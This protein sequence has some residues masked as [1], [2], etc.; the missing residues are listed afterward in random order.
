MRRM[1]HSATLTA[2]S[3][4]SPQPFKLLQHD[5][6]PWLGTA[7]GHQVMLQVPCPEV[8]CN[9]IHCIGAKPRKMIVKEEIKVQVQ[10]PNQTM[11]TLVGMRCG[12]AG[13]GYWSPMT[14]RPARLPGMLTSR[15]EQ[16]FCFPL[17]QSVASG[18]PVGTSAHRHD[19]S[20]VWDFAG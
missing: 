4:Q 18:P 20:E 17:G 5:L 9:H 3:G 19:V 1:Q 11:I 8:N 12:V 14:P 15:C 13:T 6:T 16:L 2:N 7:G 10:G